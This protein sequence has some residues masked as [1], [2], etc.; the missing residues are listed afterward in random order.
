M[1]KKI[2]KNDAVIR[3]WYTLKNLHPIEIETVRKEKLTN[4]K[5]RKQKK[6]TL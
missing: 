3:F 5:S 6:E 4:Y 2:I 1:V